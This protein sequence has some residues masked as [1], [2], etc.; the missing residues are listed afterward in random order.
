MIMIEESFRHRV[1]RTLDTGISGRGPARWIHGSII[2]LI[3]ANVAAVILESDR[4][5]AADWA[6]WFRG[7]EIFSVIVFTVEYA[8]R[9]WAVVESDHYGRLGPVRGRVR[10]ALTPLALVDLLAILP[11][12]LATLLPVD[13]RFVRVLR[14]LR[15]L[16]LAHYFSGLDVFLRVLRVQLPALAAAS[17]VMVVMVLFAAILMFM[18]ENAAQP[19]AFRNIGDAI[20]WSVVTLTTV[21]YGDTVPATAAGKVLGVVIMLLGVGT[22][23]LPAALLAA[24]FSDEIQRRRGELAEQIQNYMGDGWMTSMEREEIDRLGHE[25]GLSDASIQKMVDRSRSH[26][27]DE[28]TCPHCGKKLSSE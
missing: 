4:S 22:V 20:W 8:L 11:F 28:Q 26:P 1:Y 18:F 14:L 24:R 27:P 23:A 17:L 19:D 3:I 6:P 2:A 10:F 5:I 9:N 7:F 16:K 13:L 12:Y 21:G 15:L 25:L